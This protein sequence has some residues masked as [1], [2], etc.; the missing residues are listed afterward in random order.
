VGCIQKFLHS[1][2]A[3]GEFSGDISARS[4]IWIA[5]HPYIR[6]DRFNLGL[7][8]PLLLASPIHSAFLMKLV[9]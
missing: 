6:K 9:L 8:F 7:A 5:L 3:H 1:E 2:K 4:F